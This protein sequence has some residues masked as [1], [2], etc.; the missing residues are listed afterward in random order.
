MTR[1][2][3]RVANRILP[4]LRRVFRGVEL[5]GSL[6]H[7]LPHKR[8]LLRA[9]DIFRDLSAED[10]AWLE[11]AT[12][13]LAVRKGRVIYEQQDP[14]EGLYLLKQG[15]V[16]LFRISASGKR[17]DLLTIY[18]G[19]FF[20]EL[21]LLGEH[22]RNASAEALDDCV[23]C[24]IT[25][26]DIERLV[27]RQPRVALR[28]LEIVGRR[29]AESEARLEELAY[30]S[31]SARLASLLLRLGRED[32]QTIEGIS[33]QELGDMV[34]AYRETITKVLDEFRTAGYV[35]LGRRRIRIL[36]PEGLAA[37][38]EE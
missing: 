1:T 32:S 24:L 33:H 5:D 11:Q 7:L 3:N 17:L 12:R 15:R 35:D 20:G 36:S 22:M 26:R 8:E 9:I 37:L 25:Q 18:P 27:L 29:L 23:L 6:A 2:R 16:R 30:R 13:M 10:L 28:M 19:T 4:G 31:V 21:P 34:G 38:L 14:T